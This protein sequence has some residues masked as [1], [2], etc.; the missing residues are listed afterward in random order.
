MKLGII[1]FEM[2]PAGLNQLLHK[3]ISDLSVKHSLSG[4]TIDPVRQQSLEKELDKELLENFPFH[5]PSLLQVSY[6][7]EDPDDYQ[8]M[9]DYD[10]VIV[11]GTGQAVESLKQVKARFQ[12]TSFLFV[13][14]SIY[15]NLEETDLSLGYD[16]ALNYIMES[17]FKIRDTIDSLKY[18]DP[19]LFGIQLPGHAPE[20][21]LN[22]LAV[23]VRGHA[24]PRGYG[25]EKKQSL[26]SSLE[27]EF[28]MG[29]THSFLIFDETFE[30]DNLHEE[31]LPGL[32]VDW[33]WHKVDEA[34]CLGPDPQA[35]DRIIA[36]QFAR[37]IVE[38]VEKEEATGSLYYKNR[39]AVHKQN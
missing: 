35:A 12:R 24:L 27:E 19:R 13:P 34:L 38:W 3:L 15:N 16:T 17:I 37:R 5:Y 9:A 4:I 26:E 1:N 6:I 33:K 8:L 30:A 39:Q 28:S 20:E 36:M 25:E 29:Q 2:A 14:F 7:S 31:V 21:M 32:K 23:A 11:F 18:P 10:A 22:E